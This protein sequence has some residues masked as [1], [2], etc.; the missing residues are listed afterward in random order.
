M[1]KK[2][3]LL[4]TSHVDAHGLRTPKNVLEDM[5]KQINGPVVPGMKIEHDITL[6]PL[7]KWIRA[8]VK[9]LPDGEYGLFGDCLVFERDNTRRVTLPNGETAMIDTWQDERPFADEHVEIPD[10]IKYSFDY[11][12]FESDADV[13][14]LLSELREERPAMH[15]MLLRKSFISDPEFIISL[16]EKAI[17][18]L[19]AHAAIKTAGKVIGEKLANDLASLFTT[20]QNAAIKYA[21][22]CI[23]KNRP[24]TYVL[25]KPGT[26]SIEFVIRTI[27]PQDL[28]TGL[29]KITDTL[30]QA[31]KLQE[32][33]NAQKIQYK[34]NDE[35]NWSFNYCTTT[36][37]KVVGSRD[38]VRNRAKAVEMKLNPP[39]IQDPH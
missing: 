29:E 34:M 1:I 27:N 22:Y 36:D 5:A 14:T 24:I 8:T 20:L 3:N 16:S 38:A 26:P 30:V 11:T 35:G 31:E 17:N 21:K 13:D 33:L 25:V 6:P 23:P 19:L 18:Y 37:G 12:N 2:H 10:E 32:F 4:R 39:S 7:G 9:R 28:S 15:D